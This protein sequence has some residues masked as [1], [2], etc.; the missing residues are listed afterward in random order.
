MTRPLAVYHDARQDAGPAE[1]VESDAMKL[2]MNEETVKN[3][4]A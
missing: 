2:Q 1:S 3:A 4:F